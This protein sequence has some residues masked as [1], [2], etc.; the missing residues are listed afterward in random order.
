MEIQLWMFCGI[1]AFFIYLDQEIPLTFAFIVNDWNLSRVNYEKD[2]TAVDIFQ[3]GLSKNCLLD[4][5]IS[6]NFH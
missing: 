5:N 4:T 6:W 3:T 1:L 2:N